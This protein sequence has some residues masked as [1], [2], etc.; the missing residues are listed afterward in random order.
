M[1][2][3]ILRTSLSINMATFLPAT[4]TS[5]A[6]TKARWVYLVEGADNGWRVG[7]QFMENPYSRGPFNAE[8]LWYPL[9]GQAANMC[10][11]LRTSPAGLPESLT[12]RE[13]ACL[14]LIGIISSW[15]I[16]RRRCQ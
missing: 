13:P 9:P 14:L 12:S 3:A 7:F 8:R 16:F 5:I 10:R 11:R 15:W 1:A 2:C 6:V 4:T